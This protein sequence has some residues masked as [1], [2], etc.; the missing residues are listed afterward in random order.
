MPD[1]VGFDALTFSAVLATSESTKQDPAHLPDAPP[2][3][4]PAP[5]S[6]GHTAITA[7]D[8]GNPA[9]DPATSSSSL[10]LSVPESAE[11][12]FVNAAQLTE[13]ASRSEMRV[14]MD[15][16]KLGAVELRAHLVGNEV[17][18]AITVERREA[19]AAL[20]GELPALQQALSEKQLRIEQ[21]TLLHGSFNATAG[22]AGSSSRQ[23][24]R[25]APPSY[26]AGWSPNGALL[27]SLA[28]GESGQSFGIFDSQGRLSVRA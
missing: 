15:T 26:T 24:G 8:S 6:S 1:T 2:S 14:A 20:A 18:A 4:L 10:K 27:S 16:E 23:D 11:T 13:L 7:N 21:V 3:N 9:R 28:A 17:A 19:H 12:R 22:D 5:A 25:P